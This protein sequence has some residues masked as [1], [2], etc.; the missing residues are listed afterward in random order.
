LFLNSPKVF[1][2]DAFKHIMIATIPPT[3]KTIVKVLK[4]WKTG[5][6]LPYSEYFKWIP[7]E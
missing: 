2:I 3:T 1:S 4:K 5:D 6:K 7:A